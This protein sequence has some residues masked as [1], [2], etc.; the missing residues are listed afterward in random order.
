MN[1]D[2]L[3]YFLKTDYFS[4][5]HPPEQS[6]TK[7]TQQVK[8]KKKIFEWDTLI[9]KIQITTGYSGHCTS[10]IIINDIKLTSVVSHFTA[11]ILN[12]KII[13]KLH[14]IL[15]TIKSTIKTMD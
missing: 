10:I 1:D 6:R 5:S 11:I 15:D 13:S 9:L 7:H 8:E 3:R 14:V 12:I 2:W 4:P